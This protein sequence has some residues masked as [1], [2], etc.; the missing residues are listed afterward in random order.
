[1]DLDALRDGIAVQN[2]VAQPIDRGDAVGV[3]PH[4]LEQG[5]AGAVDELPVDDMAQRLGIDD[6]PD[7][8]GADIAHGL[9]EPAVAMHPYLGDE[10]DEG[11]EMP[12]H[13]DAAADGYLRI[14]LVATRRG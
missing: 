2:R 9:D 13:G 10:G 4:L 5:A 14:A 8:V 6:E 1:M 3:E 12:P 7:I 11:G